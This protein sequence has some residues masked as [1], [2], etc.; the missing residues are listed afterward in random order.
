M[1]LVTTYIKGMVIVF[2][3]FVINGSISFG[4]NGLERAK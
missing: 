3:N 2:L 1:G 4:Y